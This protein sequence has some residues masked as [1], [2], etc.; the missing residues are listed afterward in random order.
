MKHFV[1]KDSI[2]TL[3][4]S[5]TVLCGNW[6]VGSSELAWHPNN[7]VSLG[8]PLLPGYLMYYWGNKHNKA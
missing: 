8:L 6:A 1:S 5:K 7:T 4:K 3:R 2:W